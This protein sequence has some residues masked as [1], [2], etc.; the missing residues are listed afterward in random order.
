MA[1]RRP[2]PSGPYVGEP[3][4]VPPWWPHQ[5]PPSAQRQVLNQGGLYFLAMYGNAAIGRI[6]HVSIYFGTAA[7]TERYQD[8]APGGM[9]GGI[10]F[11]YSCIWERVEVG[12]QPTPPPR[13]KRT[14]ET[15]A[16]S[17]R[18]GYRGRMRRQLGFTTE[19]QFKTYYE[20]TPDLSFLRRHKAR[21]YVAPGIGRIAF[22]KR[23]RTNPYSF[24]ATWQR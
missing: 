16:P 5:Y 19:A 15:L 1:S 18:S 12:P 13:A 7:E 6:D 2:R 9:T 3:G 21:T 4:E 8:G 10:A 24:M 23:A 20:T 14:W 11:E 17:T 22:P